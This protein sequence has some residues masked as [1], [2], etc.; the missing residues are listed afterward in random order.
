MDDYVVAIDVGGTTIKTLLLTEAGVELGRRRALTRCSTR[1]VTGSRDD[2]VERVLD[3]AQNALQWAR[4]LTGREPL[5]LAVASL[6]LVDQEAGIARRSAALGWRDVPLRS[7]LATRTGLPT[8]LG[9]D[10]QAAAL[11]EATLGQGRDEESFFFVAIGTGVG[12]ALVRR[13]VVDSG[14]SGAAGELGHIPVSP[15]RSG[16]GQSRHCGCGAS[17][18]LE[19]EASATALARGYQ[20]RTGRRVT[21]A[22]V[23]ALAGTDDPDAVAVWE[24]LIAALASGLV[25][26]AALLDPGLIVLGGGVALAG[27]Q[28]L[29][30]L[31]ERLAAGYRLADPPRLAVSTLAD[32]GAGL[33]AALL[34]WR[35]LH[36]VARAELAR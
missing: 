14:L 36:S 18:C 15:G 31:R 22:E 3:E 12:A 28:L 29:Q 8:V 6:G 32:R 19:T 11:A 33:G 25:T 24:D 21:A 35:H 17:G 30:P 16:D 26:A 23:A 2:V 13:G 10:L 34:G 27:E 20:T 4:H 1:D 7:L 9:Q 5:A